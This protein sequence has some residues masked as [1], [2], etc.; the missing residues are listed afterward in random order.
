MKGWGG[1]SGGGL[2][3]LMSW[4]GERLGR[5]PCN[6]CKKIVHQFILNS[7]N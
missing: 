7:E 5:Q 6:L 1:R 3:G 4:G 2:E